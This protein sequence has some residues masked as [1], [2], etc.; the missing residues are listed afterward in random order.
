MRLKSCAE[1]FF[2]CGHLSDIHQRI[3]LDL[4]IGILKKTYSHFGRVVCCT[5][6]RSAS[7]LGDRKESPALYLLQDLGGRIVSPHIPPAVSFVFSMDISF[8]E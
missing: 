2:F 4:Q 7:I 1:F 6:T 5:G 8:V 3:A